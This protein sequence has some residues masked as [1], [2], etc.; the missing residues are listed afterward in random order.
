MT[1]SHKLPVALEDS[2]KRIALERPDSRNAA[3]A[4]IILTGDNDLLVLKEFRGIR[5]FSP[6]QFVEYMDRES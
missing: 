6:R 4:E 3:R 2:I 5:I 1:R